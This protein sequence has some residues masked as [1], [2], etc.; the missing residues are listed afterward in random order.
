MSAPVVTCGPK[1]NIETAMGA[2]TM[3]KIRH[4]PVVETVS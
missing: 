3:A 2:M 4:L 1:D